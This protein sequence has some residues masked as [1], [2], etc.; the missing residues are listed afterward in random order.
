MRKKLPWMKLNGLVLAGGELGTITKMQENTIDGT[1]YVYYI[2]V[3]LG[4]KKF[5]A[6]YHP[7]DIQPIVIINEPSFAS[8]AIGNE[9][10]VLPNLPEEL[11]KLGFAAFDCLNGLIGQTCSICDLHQDDDINPDQWYA[12]VDICQEVPIQCLEK[13]SSTSKTE[14]A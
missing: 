4:G 13:I 2:D 8:F 10:R 3:Q 5:S 7:G 6:P 14:E 1:D 9:V 12:T 11:K